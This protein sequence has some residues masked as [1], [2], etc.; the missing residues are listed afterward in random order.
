MT[1]KKINLKTALLQPI[2]TAVPHKLFGV[3][4]H[5]RRL[6]VCELMDYDEGLGKAQAE[7][8]QKAAT[9]LGAQLILSAL[10]DEQGKSV[11]ASDLPSPAELL[12]AHDNAALFDAIR[13]IQNHSYGTLE[14]AEKN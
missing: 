9:L 1:Q 11:P 14:E 4:V 6:T 3:P 13:A 7:S 8:D 2:N 12:A 10:V 5:I